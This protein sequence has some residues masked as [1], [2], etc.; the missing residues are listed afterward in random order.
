MGKA[1]HAN[2]VVAGGH[3][4]VVGVRRVD[5]HHVPAHAHGAPRAVANGGLGVAGAGTAHGTSGHVPRGAMGRE[6]REGRER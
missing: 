1:R 2:V 3:A 6:G 5:L 4:A